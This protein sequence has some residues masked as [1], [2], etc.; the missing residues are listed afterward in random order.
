MSIFR[1]G[2]LYKIGALAISVVLLVMAVAVP[3]N[4]A[5]ASVIPETPTNFSAEATHNQVAL[6]WEIGSSPNLK[7]QLSRETVGD[8]DSDVSVR[9]NRSARSYIDTTVAQNTQY[10]YTL[11]AVNRGWAGPNLVSDAAELTVTTGILAEPGRPTGLTGSPI[12]GT[13]LTLTWDTPQDSE[14]ITGY[15]ILRKVKGTS[16][17][18]HLVNNTSNGSTTY[19]DNS[20]TAGNTYMY[21]IRATNDSGFG[22]MSRKASV[23]VPNIPSTPINVGV[24]YLYD[25]DSDTTTATITWDDDG[26]GTITMFEIQRIHVK[27]GGSERDETLF[28]VSVDDLDLS[29]VS[30]PSDNGSSDSYYYT[31]IDTFGGERSDWNLGYS[32]KAINSS[33]TGQPSVALGTSVDRDPETGFLR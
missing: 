10:R 8:P 27:H 31:Y 23:A 26:D 21:K 12:T 16:G 33:G 17:F 19:V 9:V 25:D 28:T 22:R 1:Q 7:F 29:S 4:A 6:T 14:L 18:S 3:Q 2:L 5:F 24:D 13:S 32:L 15:R 20:V 11:N 30:R